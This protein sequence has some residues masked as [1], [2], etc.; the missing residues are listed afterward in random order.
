MRSGKSREL[1]HDRRVH[2]GTIKNPSYKDVCRRPDMPRLSKSSSIPS[3]FLPGATG[4]LFPD[5]RPDHV[6]SSG[7]DFGT[8]Y[9]SAIFFHDPSR[10]PRR[11]NR[12]RPSRK[13][14]S[15]SAPSLPRLRRRRIFIAGKIT[16]SNISR[17][18]H[19]VLPSVEIGR[20]SRCESK[21]FST[22][23]LGHPIDDSPL[24]HV[25]FKGFAETA[26]PEASYSC[27]YG[28][29]ANRARATEPGSGFTESS[30][31]AL[32]N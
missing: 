32:Q 9:R 2:G 13:R 7:P 21:I 26:D 1:L 29:W 25:L 14:K 16:T 6:E 17:S 19:P 27:R 31:T 15:S 18:G 5:P 22:L 28:E 24:V 4:R 23:N 20:A 30:Y 3:G 10:K 11:V 8:Q 12:K